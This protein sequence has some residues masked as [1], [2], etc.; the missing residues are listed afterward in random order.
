MR[1]QIQELAPTVQDRREA[2]S[3][4]E[5]LAGCLGRPLLH[6]M[7]QMGWMGCAQPWFVV[8]VLS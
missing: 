1:V 3:G 5:P 7:K 6:R 8:K 4:V 2:E